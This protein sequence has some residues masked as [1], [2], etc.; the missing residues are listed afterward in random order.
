MTHFFIAS[1]PFPDLG[2]TDRNF[3]LVS[4]C[5]K[6]SRTKKSFEKLHKDTTNPR[7]SSEPPVSLHGADRS[8]RGTS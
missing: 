6:A 3:W 5:A 4:P 7:A 8:A 2:K 1:P